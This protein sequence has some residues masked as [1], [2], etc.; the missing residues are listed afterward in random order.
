MLQ[1]LEDELSKVKI[2][3]NKQKII[4]T[5]VNKKLLSKIRYCFKD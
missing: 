3:N 5:M 1:T 4:K 2:V